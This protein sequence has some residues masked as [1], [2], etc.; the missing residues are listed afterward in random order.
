MLIGQIDPDKVTL[1][2]HEF[3]A[4]LLSLLEI[5]SVAPN[6]DC[7]TQ[8]AEFALSFFVQFLL[9]VVD[10]EG[11]IIKFTINIIFFFF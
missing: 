3:T 11:F 6:A 4:A 5:T 8:K 7:S 1:C 10:R 9:S 2:L